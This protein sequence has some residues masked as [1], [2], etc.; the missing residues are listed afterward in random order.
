[1][2]W[3]FE[4]REAV[5]SLREAARKLQRHQGSGWCCSLVNPVL[6]PKGVDT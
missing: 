5:C 2:M 6:G 1:M 4:V 3:K